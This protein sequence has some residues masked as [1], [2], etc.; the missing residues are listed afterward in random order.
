MTK[1]SLTLLL[2]G[3]CNGLIAM[4]AVKL[5][6]QKEISSR[7]SNLGMDHFVEKTKIDK[8][9]GD[10]E[11]YPTGVSL[12][13]ELALYDYNEY[14]K[15]PMMANLMQMRKPEIITAILQD[16]PEAIESLKKDGLLK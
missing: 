13:V 16:H 14:L 1:I 2:L 15:Q 6:S 3:A 11:R 9:L 10:Q 12:A 5:P 8:T 7:I 4:E